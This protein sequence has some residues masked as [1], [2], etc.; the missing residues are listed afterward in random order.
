MKDKEI[1]THIYD[2]NIWGTGSGGGSDYAV[3]KEYCSYLQQFMADN[4]VKDVTDYGCGDWS[5]SQYIKWDGIEY[6][7]IDVVE[8]VISYNKNHYGKENINFICHDWNLCGDLLLL[9]DVLQHW[10]NDKIVDFLKKVIPR[11]RFVLITNSSNQT[12]DWEDNEHPHLHA[13]SLS[14][15]FDP[16]KGFGAVIVLETN[17]NEPKETCLII[18]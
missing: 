10:H 4:D 11:Y 12:K 2:N 7:G 6:W 3:N 17:I 14:A 8:S 15:R 1:F 5:F 18:K 9:K 13:R 16:L